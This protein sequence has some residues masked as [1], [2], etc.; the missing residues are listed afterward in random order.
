MRANSVQEL[1]NALKTGRHKVFVVGGEEPLLIEES[2]DLVRDYAKQQGFLERTVLSVDGQFK[3]NSLHEQSDNLSLFASAKLLDVRL[4]KGKPGREGSKA[5]SEFIER[6]DDQTRLLVVCHD[7]ANKDTKGK[8]VKTLEANGLMQY[9]WKVSLDQFPRWLHNR[10]NE[11]GVYLDEAA[12][13]FLVEHVEGNLLAADQE[14]RKLKMLYGSDAITRETLEG[15]IGDSSRFDPYLL[16]DYCISG[17][18][19]R[20]LRI[21]NS[22]EKEGVSTVPVQWAL[23]NRIR[24]MY[25][26]KK[27]Q[28]NHQNPSAIYQRSMVWKSRQAAMSKSARRMSSHHWQSLL[29]QCEET[30][31]I[32]K[33]KIR[34]DGWKNL[35]KLVA[36]VALQPS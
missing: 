20:S 8:W 11:V 28:E 22:L 2:A 6:L 25:E 15:I 17:E 12:K 18:L 9:V 33:G 23:D 5:L 35:R 34:L 19:K 26:L 30:E 14:L 16:A 27:S 1:E 36:D 21:I 3:W 32:I 4:P 24:L 13:Q 7:W 31:K 10:M 29:I